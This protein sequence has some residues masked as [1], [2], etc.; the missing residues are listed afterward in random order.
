[1]TIRLEMLRVAGRA[2]KLLN[3]S[4]IPFVHSRHSEDGGYRGRKIEYA[5]QLLVRLRRD[6][7]NDHVTEVDV[8]KSRHTAKPK[9]IRCGFEW[10][11]GG[12]IPLRTGDENGD[13]E[14]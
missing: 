3:D 8:M 10:N 7:D 13:I 1:M 12:L 14:L 4:V 5:A 9:A 2:R 11:L 6:A